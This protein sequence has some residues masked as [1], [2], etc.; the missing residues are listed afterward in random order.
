[1]E[2]IFLPHRMTAIRAWGRDVPFSEGGE[3]EKGG[4]TRVR[5]S[6]R[7]RPGHLNPQEP[8]QNPEQ[9]KELRMGE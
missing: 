1:M 9:Q 3:R 5:N 8:P 2:E 7:E 4:S 6:R